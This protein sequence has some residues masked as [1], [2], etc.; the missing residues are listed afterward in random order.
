MTPLKVLVVCG[1]NRLRSPTAV[2]IYKNI[3]EI[4]MRSAGLSSASLHKINQSDIL[5]ADL[6]LYMEKNHI[7]KI[8]KLF[9]TT[10]MPIHH[11]LNIKDKYSFMELTLVSAL[12]QKI[13]TILKEYDG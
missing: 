1:R 13:D 5:W 6:I 7:E 4:K 8:K 2:E 9:P 11:N 3:P 12:K 10:I